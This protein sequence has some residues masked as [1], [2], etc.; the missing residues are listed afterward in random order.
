MML[1]GIVFVV[2]VFMITAIGGVQAAD[3]QGVFPDP[4]L[5]IEAKAGKDVVITLESNRTTGFE[6]QLSEPLDKNIIEFKSSEYIASDGKLVGAG[7]KEVWTFRAIGAG[8]TFIVMKYARPWEKDVAPA[9][10][11]IFTISVK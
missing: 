4:S 9:M 5:V 10:K 7:G 3:N 2:L 8:K 1:K 6:W 11:E